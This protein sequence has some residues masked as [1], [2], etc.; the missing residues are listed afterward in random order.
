[1]ANYR[2]SLHTM[3]GN[4]FD[5]SVACCTHSPKVV[6]TSL[7]S[8]RKVSISNLYALISTLNLLF[9]CIHLSAFCNSLNCIWRFDSLQRL[10]ARLF[11][12]L[13]SQY[14]SS[15]FSK[16]TAVRFF[17]HFLFGRLHALI[18]ETVLL[19]NDVLKFPFDEDLV[20]NRSTLYP[21]CGVKGTVCV[22]EAFPVGSQPRG[23][24]ATHNGIKQPN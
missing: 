6:L 8:L 24:E 15:F 1:M 18:V 12:R 2:S 17:L 13:L 19:S 21:S 3:G 9:S 22:L 4:R 5:D 10:A 11:L 7:R 14:L 23:I 16:G 20:V